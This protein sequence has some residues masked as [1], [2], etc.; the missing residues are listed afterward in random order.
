MIS[1]ADNALFKLVLLLMLMLTLMMAFNRGQVHS[2]E[3][4]VPFLCLEWT[5]KV[6]SY[7]LQVDGNE[8]QFVSW[9]VWWDGALIH[10]SLSH[11]KDS[12]TQRKEEPEIDWW[13]D[14]WQADQ[15]KD[16][17]IG[18]SRPTKG[19]WMYIINPVCLCVCVFSQNKGGLTSAFAPK[20]PK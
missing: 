14:I 3:I 17:L 13:R 20:V 8:W 7:I 15:R 4:C 5:G 10:K 1:D 9:F 11:C 16:P 19:S 2:V 18:V 6:S 12:L